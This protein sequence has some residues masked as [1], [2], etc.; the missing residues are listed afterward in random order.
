MDTELSKRLDQINQALP[1]CIQTLNGRIVSFE[2]ESQ[3]LWMSYRAEPAFCHSETIVQGGFVSGMVDATMAHCCMVLLRPQGLLAT[4][5]LELKVSF[6]APAHPGELRARAWPLKVGKSIAYL[7]AELYQKDPEAERDR[8]IV[9][10]SS[11]LK[12][13]YAKK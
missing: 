5:T 1:P 13:V 4:P 10:A 3:S 8:L 12:L 6:L 7:E 2:Q 9:K 11:T